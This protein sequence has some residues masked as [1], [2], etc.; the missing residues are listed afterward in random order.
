MPKLDT[1]EK[2]ASPR[3]FR[4]LGKYLSAS[5]ICLGTSLCGTLTVANIA[6]TVSFSGADSTYIDI[7]PFFKYLKN[8]NIY[9]RSVLVKLLFL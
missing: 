8:S 1:N 5:Y 4:V 7:D 9:P 6:S 3:I 2:M